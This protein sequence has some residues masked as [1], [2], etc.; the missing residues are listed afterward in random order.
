SF[1]MSFGAVVGLVAA[2][3]WWRVRNEG[4]DIAPTGYLSRFLRGLGGTAATSLVAG[5][6]SAPF[7]A[8][9]FNRFANYGVA[10][11]LLAMPVVSFVIMPFGVIA[12]LLMPLGLDGPPLQVM[13]WGIRVM[14]D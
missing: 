10:A 3:E 7:A 6:A 11:N 2:F 12:L 9:H 4:Q 14:L 5:L 13:A 8:Y 1:Q